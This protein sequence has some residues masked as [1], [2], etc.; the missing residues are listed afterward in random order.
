[1]KFDQSFWC[2]RLGWL[3]AG[4]QTEWYHFGSDLVPLQL[5]QQLTV[6]ILKNS[7]SLDLQKWSQAIWT[8]NCICRQQRYFET[9]SFYVILETAT[10]LEVAFRKQKTIR[11]DLQVV[12][13]FLHHMLDRHVK[14]RYL[15]ERRLT[16]IL[17][18]AI[19]CKI[20]FY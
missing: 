3:R 2:I 14:H 10:I 4:Y 9:R 20:D 12:S 17:E 6:L 13:R 11:L 19:N 1:M 5:S 15:G 8:S 16:L 7:S 18:R